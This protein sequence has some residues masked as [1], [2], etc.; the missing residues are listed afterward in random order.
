MSYNYP[1]CVF[2]DVCEGRLRSN[3]PF[4]YLVQ[5]SLQDVMKSPLILHYMAKS[6]LANE[7]HHD[8]VAEKQRVQEIIQY[9]E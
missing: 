8:E 6:T 2:A 9:L 4:Y 7:S 1:L 5:D 3:H